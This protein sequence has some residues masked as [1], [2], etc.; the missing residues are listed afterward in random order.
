MTELPK[1]TNVLDKRQ[2][3]HN[4][5]DQKQAQETLIRTGGLTEDELAGAEQFLKDVKITPIKESN[6]N[7]TGNE[8][9][10]S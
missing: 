4:W 10:G 2:R 6:D 7:A 9:S 3:L 1:P 5:M 8:S